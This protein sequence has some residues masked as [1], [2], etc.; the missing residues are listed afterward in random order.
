MRF[1]L[2]PVLALCLGAAAC[3]DMSAGSA[4]STAPSAPVSAPGVPIAVESI[5][6]APSGVA[7]SFNSAFLEAA[8]ARQVELVGAKTGVR[9]R[10][11]GYLSAE[12]AEGGKTELTYVWDVFDSARQRAQRLT[13]ATVARSASAADPWTAVDQTVAAR[14]ASDSMDVIAAFLRESGAVASA[15]TSENAGGATSRVRAARQ[16]RNASL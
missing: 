3:T 10:I 9:Y 2:V 6:G 4:I 14:A 1:L 15:S 12:P 11:K 5:S 13:G 7:A 8:S 16:T